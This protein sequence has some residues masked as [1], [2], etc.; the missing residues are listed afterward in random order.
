MTS[1]LMCGVL[2][3]VAAACSSCSS[4]G[5]GGGA[6]VTSPP[7]TTTAVKIYFD[8]PMNTSLSE[9]G[10]VL[11]GSDGKPTGIK[12]GVWK[13]FYPENVSGGKDIMESEKTYDF[14]TWNREKS[15][16]VFNPDTSIRDT[17]YDAIF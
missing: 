16:T 5:G 12:H 15:W 10:F 7:P 1:R 2:L 6:S 14:G 8:P 9:E 13:T 17:M 11:V 4:S 3:I